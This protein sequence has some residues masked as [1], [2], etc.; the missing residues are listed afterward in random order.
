MNRMPGFTAENALYQTAHQGYLLT[1]NKAVAPCLVQ[2][3]SFSLVFDPSVLYVN[4]IFESPRW[5][6]RCGPCECN[7]VHSGIFL[8]VTCWKECWTN[9]FVPGREDISMRSYQPCSPWE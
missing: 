4:P 7:W 5:S 2:T 8:E 1:G 3:S 9:W 6:A